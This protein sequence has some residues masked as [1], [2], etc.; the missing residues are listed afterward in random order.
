MAS[1]VA[2]AAE[3]AVTVL[4]YEVTTTTTALDVIPTTE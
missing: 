3:T 2:V 1:A 4:R